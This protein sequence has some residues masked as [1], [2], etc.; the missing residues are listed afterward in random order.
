MIHGI[1]AN[2]YFYDLLGESNRATKSEKINQELH[3]LINFVICMLYNVNEFV[4]SV[5]VMSPL[6][7]IATIFQVVSF[8][9]DGED[10]VIEGEEQTCAKFQ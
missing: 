4:F 3:I 10:V 9:K 6:F 2:L 8:C 5:C 1:V 7:L